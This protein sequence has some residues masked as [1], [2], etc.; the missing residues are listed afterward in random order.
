MFAILKVE[1]TDVPCSILNISLAI[2]ELGW[3]VQ[4]E[5]L[6]GLEKTVAWLQNNDQGNS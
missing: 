3:N 1:K 2:S 6:E 4:T 5:Y